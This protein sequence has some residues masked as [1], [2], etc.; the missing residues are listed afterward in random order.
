VLRPTP[1]TGMIMKRFWHCLRIAALLAGL[2]CPSIPAGC[3]ESTEPP[4]DGQA[5]ET[6]PIEILD[7]PQEIEL[8]GDTP[9]DVATDLPYEPDVTDIRP[10]DEE[11]LHSFIGGPCATAD[12]CVVP[13]GLTA[14]CL[15]DLMTIIVMPGGYCTAQCQ[16][17]ADCGPDAACVDLSIVRFC[18]RTCS[19]VA[20][21]RLEDGYYCDIIPYISDP[22][23]YCIPPI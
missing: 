16:E 23:T 1:G 5:D 10:D 2:V 7:T 8:V 19:S 14:Q 9:P 15:T 20:D 13:E 17:V 4:E 6:P 18:I 12:D 11:P 22:S 3:A 21:C